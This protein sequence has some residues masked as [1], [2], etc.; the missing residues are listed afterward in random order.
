MHAPN[1]W[2][3]VHFFTDG[4]R[5]S[6]TN[7]NWVEDFSDKVWLLEKIPYSGHLSIKPDAIRV[8]HRFN[9]TA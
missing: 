2:T 5:Y 1:T 9:W 4:P 8:E 3:E 7:R 6:R